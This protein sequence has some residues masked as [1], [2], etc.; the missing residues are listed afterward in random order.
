M[1]SSGSEQNNPIT[2]EIAFAKK[3]IFDA[4]KGIPTGIKATTL[5]F[6]SPGEPTQDMDIMREC[7]EYAR[8][9]N[10]NIRL[11]LQTNGLFKTADDTEWIAKNFNAVW[12]SLDGPKDV[13]DKHRPD[14]K[15]CGRTNE[16]EENLRVVQK[17]IFVGIR[18]TVV[19]E[20]MDKQDSLIDYYHN[21]GVKNVCLNPLIRQI[22]RNESGNTEVTKDD[23]MVFSDNFL[24]AYKRGEALGVTVLSSLTFNFD[25]KTSVACRSCL[26][27]PQ[28][29]PDGSVSSCDMAL[30]KDTKK[31]L[32]DFIYGNWNANESNICYDEDKITI[33]RS[34]NLAN[35]PKCANC[36]AKEY[37][38]GG[39]AGRVAF[40]TGS[41]F[42]VIPDY[43]KATIYLAN[44]IPCGQN[45][46]PDNASHP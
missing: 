21:L 32:Q 18:S 29:N 19:E 10:P 42:D 16:I 23:I 38:A 9:L 28:L 1:A 13:N 33:L 14:D 7:V 41:L 31:E 26:P 11:E 5:R 39:C 24:K 15:G 20:T 3:G 30:Y 46:I 37:C 4:I 6:F 2:I 12:F 43:C 40:Q 36:P 34:R 35:L 44:A 8:S 17:H 45:R 27:M 25:E 22:V